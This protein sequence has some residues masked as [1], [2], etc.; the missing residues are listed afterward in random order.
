MAGQI[1]MLALAVSAPFSAAQ[2]E[3]WARATRS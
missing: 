2:G 3:A 1:L